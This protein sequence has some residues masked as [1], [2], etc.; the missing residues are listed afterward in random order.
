MY[1]YYMDKIKCNKCNKNIKLMIFEC[2]C[3]HHFCLNHK[4][5]ES[6]MCSYNFKVDGI[7][8]LTKNNPKI[9]PSKLIKI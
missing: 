8:E 2:K 9:I 4:D 5:P 3:H 1:L 7:N 6:H